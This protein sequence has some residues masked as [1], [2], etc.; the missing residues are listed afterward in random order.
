MKGVAKLF[1]GS[2]F[3]VSS[4]SAGS[5]EKGYEAYKNNDYIGAFKEWHSMAK[6]G[7][8]ITQYLIG[9]MYFS[10][11]GVKQSYKMALNWFK[12]SAK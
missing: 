11:L 8:M 6:D 1:V 3:M 2:L 7:N 10:G 9:D 5:I 12:L 4:L